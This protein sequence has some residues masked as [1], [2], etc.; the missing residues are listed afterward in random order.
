MK[1]LQIINSLSTGGAEKLVCESTIL[2]QKHRLVVDVLS[3]SKDKTIFWQELKKLTNGRIFGLTYKTI[4]NPLLVF[5]IIPYL[6]RYDIIQ[7]HLFPSL[8]W[9]VLAKWI[10]F[11]KT[12]IIYTEHST[13]NRRRGIFLFRILDR[14]IYS[15]I[16]NVVCIS[17]DVEKNLKRHLASDNSKFRKI[18]N[19]ISVEIFQNAIAYPK[20]RFFNDECFILTQVSSFR[21]PKDQSTVIKSLQYLPEKVK[22]ILVGDGP[23]I[24]IHKDLV[25]RLNLN[26]RVLFLGNRSD[27]PQILKTSDIIVLSSEY[28]GL[29]LS[30]IEGMAAGKPFIGSCVPGVI[31]VVKG[32]GLLFN[33]GEYTDLALKI[34]KLLD[35]TEYYHKVASRCFNRAQ[36][37]DIERMI[38]S[39]IDLYKKSID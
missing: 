22:L 3:L 33:V 5:K 23:L 39:Y 31:D 37:F 4:Y 30:N 25:K 1:I 10:S 20:N 11:S 34:K 24:D 28:E 18:Y 16:K 15:G 21:Y 2:F 12:K 9:V 35:S 13:T 29:S 38:S 17:D 36:S 14:I 32:Y 19:G 26:C 7:V 27:I 8:Y 6:N